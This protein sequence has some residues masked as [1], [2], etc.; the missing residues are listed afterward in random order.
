MKLS[1]VLFEAR[2]KIGFITI[3]NVEK[4][5][6]IDEDVAD[7]LVK[8]INECDENDDIRVVI[9]RGAGGNFSSGGDLK[10]LKERLDSDNP[11]K[12]SVAL[13]RFNDVAMRLRNIRK[14]TISYI[15]GAAAGAGASF[16]MC[17]DF[18]IADENSKFVFA[19][20]NVV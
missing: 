20:A 9:L 15:E 12:K 17:C 7:S 18:S 3:D 2:D 1:K 11:T 8:C 10:A 5:N 14:P 6:A 16:A 4:R 13:V 19:F